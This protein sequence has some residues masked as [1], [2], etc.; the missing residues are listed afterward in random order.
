M[1]EHIT[2]PASKQ[3]MLNV[4]TEYEGL[5]RLAEERMKQPPQSN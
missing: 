2:D 4:A 3:M 1:A 5:A